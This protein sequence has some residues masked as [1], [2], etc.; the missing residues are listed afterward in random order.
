MGSLMAASACG[1]G[2]SPKGMRWHREIE[3]ALE[4]LNLSTIYVSVYVGEW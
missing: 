1:G 2:G 3:V 4:A